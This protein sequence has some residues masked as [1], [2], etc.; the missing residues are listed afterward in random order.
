MDILQ[1]ARFDR[2]LVNKCGNLLP[3]LRWL[4]TNNITRS[5]QDINIVHFLCREISDTKIGKSQM[6]ILMYYKAIATAG[7]TSSFLLSPKQ[8]RKEPFGSF[9]NHLVTYL[10]E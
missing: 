9:P 6:A 7:N 8:W 2:L 1:G 10:D 3:F 4:L 5:W